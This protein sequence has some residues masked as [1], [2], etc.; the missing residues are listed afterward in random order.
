MNEIIKDYID[1]G[2]DFV[3]KHKEYLMYEQNVHPEMTLDF[4]YSEIKEMST[5]VQLEQQD[6]TAELLDIIKP[7]D[8]IW[9]PVEGKIKSE[10]IEQIEQTFN[11]SLPNSYKEY[12][13]YKHFY[14]IFL[15]ADIRLYPKPVEEWYD[16]LIDNNNKIKEIVLDNKYFAIGQFSDYG[17]IC[18]DLNEKTNEPKIVMLNYETAEPEHL[19]DSFVNLLKAALEIS[20][21]IIKELKPWQIKMYKME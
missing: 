1:K 15:N 16:I 20:E 19:C 2:I 6:A 9:K 4:D 18:F 7:T 17:E 14:T 5:K 12:L 21:P 3:S 8:K 11:I 10:Q 13:M